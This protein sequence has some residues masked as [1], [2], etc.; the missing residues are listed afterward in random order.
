MLV[1]KHGSIL[2]A[3]LCLLHAAMLSPMAAVG[4]GAPEHVEEC[5]A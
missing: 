2:I 5:P 3:C 1:G 4:V